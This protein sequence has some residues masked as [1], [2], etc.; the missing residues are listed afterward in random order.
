MADADSIM[1]SNNFYYD[2]PQKTEGFFLKG[3]NSLVGSQKA[4]FLGTFDKLVQ[5]KHIIA[6]LAEFNNYSINS[7]FILINVARLQY[8]TLED[9]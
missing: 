4:P 8:P 6:V 3:S 1:E 5:L 9:H 7:I 2:T